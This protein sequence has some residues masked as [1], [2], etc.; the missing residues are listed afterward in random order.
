M[1]VPVGVDRPSLI[2]PPDEMLVNP[3][4]LGMPVFRAPV[5][6]LRR[7]PAGPLFETYA[8]CFEDVWKTCR[9][10]RDGE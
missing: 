1:V 9:P 10:Y 4:I 6:Y 2:D 7:I 3:H 8:E 5:L